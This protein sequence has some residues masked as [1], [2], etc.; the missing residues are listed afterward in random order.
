MERCGLCRRIDR[1]L[2]CYGFL[3]P[4]LHPGNAPG[5]FYFWRNR[6]RLPLYPEQKN[7]LG[8]VDGG[9]PGAYARHQR[10]VH[11]RFWLNAFGPVAH[12][13]NAASER[14]F[15]KCRKSNKTLTSYCRSCC[16]RSCLCSV[17]FIIS[18]QPRR[19]SGFGPDLCNLFRPRGRKQPSH[20]PVVLLPQDAHLF[21]IW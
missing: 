20:P 10:N 7:Y 17:L 1:Y 12:A 21:Q 6:F 16:R 4:L 19:N 14:G 2:T 5:L 3:Q 9:V 18:Y 13:L 15:H 8:L 11:Y